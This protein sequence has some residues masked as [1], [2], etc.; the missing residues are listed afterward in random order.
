ME[1]QTLI[2]TNQAQVNSIPPLRTSLYC[3]ILPL[4]KS[5][6]L[7]TT[8]NSGIITLNPH[9][10]IAMN[11]IAP[12]TKAFMGIAP[13]KLFYVL[14]GTFPTRLIHRTIQIFLAVSSSLLGNIMYFRISSPSKLSKKRNT[15]KYPRGINWVSPTPSPSI[16]SILFTAQKS[17]RNTQISYKK[18]GMLSFQ[19][20]QIRLDRRGEVQWESQQL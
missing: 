18:C 1:K 15:R 14:V 8:S 12:T 10:N 13:P 11:C 6:V 19:A 16:P 3:V 7:L 2:L 17:D 9:Q 4:C 20:T 5:P